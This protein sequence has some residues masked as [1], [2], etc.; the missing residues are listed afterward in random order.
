MPVRH[1]ARGNTRVHWINRYSGNELDTQSKWGVLAV[2]SR[3]KQHIIAAGRADHAISF[4]LAS[5][6]LFTCLHADSIVSVA[7]GAKTMTREIFW[8]HDGPSTIYGHEFNAIVF[9][10]NNDELK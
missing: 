4:T 1:L 3:D 8:F 6:T 7:A 9:R 10:R 5:N 2:V